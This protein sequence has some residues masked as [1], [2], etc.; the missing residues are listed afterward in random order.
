MNIK[1][2]YGIYKQHT[3]SNCY[4]IKILGVYNGVLCCRCVMFPYPKRA[5]SSATP[6]VGIFL[7]VFVFSVLKQKL[8][9]KLK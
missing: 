5:A 9:R 2:N 4:V 6:E 7:F 1:I 3:A 8:K